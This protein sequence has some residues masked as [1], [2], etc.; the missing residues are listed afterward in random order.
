MYQTRF[1]LLRRP[2]PPTPETASYYP[3]T[4]HEQALARVLRALSDDDGFALVA[5]GPGLGK[6]L[7]CHCLID[8]LGDGAASA[9][10]THGRFP[11]RAGLLQAVCYDLGLPYQGLAEQ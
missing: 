3:A 8:R 10:L 2:F 6:T 1:G 11:D 5:A 4:G 7:L 9:L